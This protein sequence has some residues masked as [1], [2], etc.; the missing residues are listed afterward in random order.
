MYCILERFSSILIKNVRFVSF[1]RIWLPFHS[2][3]RQKL[4]RVSRRH[5]PRW[6]VCSRVALPACI[7]TQTNATNWRFDSTS[8]L[9]L[10][11]PRWMNL[12]SLL[13]VSLFHDHF[14]SCFIRFLLRC[15]NRKSHIC[16]LYFGSLA[17]ISYGVT[18]WIL[19]WWH[20]RCQVMDG[21]FPH[22]L[23]STLLSQPPFKSLIFPFFS[24]VVL[25]FENDDDWIF[26]IVTR[27]IAYLTSERNF[28]LKFVF[29]F[30][31]DPPLA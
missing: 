1:R 29:S 19:L 31:R 7:S 20:P 22:P 10:C 5:S 17:F 24:T 27:I 13:F 21:T 18:E 15:H 26:Y 9:R 30:I 16:S 12:P 6:H 3:M 23:L 28:C 25:H 11:S 14:D 4:S 8:N 2:T